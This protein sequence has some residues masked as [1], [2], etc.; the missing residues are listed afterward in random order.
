[1]EEED[2][3][4]KIYA[5][6]MQNQVTFPS[7][8]VDEPA[9]TLIKKLLNKNVPNRLVGGFTELKNSQYF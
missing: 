7:F 9:K 3:P 1:M 2:N 5:Y 8:L 6:I 4:Y